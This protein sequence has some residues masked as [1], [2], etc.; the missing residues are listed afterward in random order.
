MTSRRWYAVALC[1]VLAQAGCDWPQNVAE[2]RT[3]P[4]HAV[5]AHTALPPGLYVSVITAAD[6]PPG[7]PVEVIELLTGTW[8]LD[9]QSGGRY[10]VSLN[11]APL[12]EGVFTANPARFVMR[13]LAGPLSCQLEHQRQANAVY[14]WSLIGGALTL[15]VVKDHCAERAFILTFQEWQQQ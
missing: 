3:D 8:T 11:G 7:F 2:P 5:A 15:Q 14:S 9:L 1:T 12:V 4:A 6:F 13:D 10:V